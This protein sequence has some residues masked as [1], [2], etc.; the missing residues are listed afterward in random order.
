MVCL[1]PVLRL[2]DFSHYV[3]F[4]KVYVYLDMQ[5]T[6]A[7]VAAMTAELSLL[8]EEML[9]QEE[10]ESKEKKGRRH[11]QHKQDSLDLRQRLLNSWDGKVGSHFRHDCMC[12]QLNCTHGEAG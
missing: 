10:V 6:A 7:Q 1:V 12:G 9:P 4:L 11:K 2:V 8:A 5:D 3:V